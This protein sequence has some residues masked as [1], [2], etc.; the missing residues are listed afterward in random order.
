MCEYMREH[1]VRSHP[2]PNPNPSA[3]NKY[4]LPQSKPI[5]CQQ[6]SITPTQT[7]PLPTISV[8]RYGSNFIGIFEAQIMASL[9]HPTTIYICANL[10]A[11]I[12][13]DRIPTPTQIHPL[14]T[15]R[16]NQDL[17]QPCPM[18]YARSAPK[19]IRL[20]PRNRVSSQI[21]ALSL[22]L[23]QRNPV[24]ICRERPQV[25]RRGAM[26]APLRRTF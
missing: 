21:L 12:M 20:K 25:L 22:R 23:W 1:N 8:V 19:P 14:P 18:I 6:I 13:C 26:L 2:N 16:Q 9:T 7:Y 24:S 15:L 17:G 3:A 5:R 4:L 10:C 11:N